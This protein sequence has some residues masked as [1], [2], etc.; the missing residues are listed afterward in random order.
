MNGRCSATLIFIILILKFNKS[1][2]TTPHTYG[3]MLWAKCSLTFVITFIIPI[4]IDIRSHRFEIFTL[5]SEI[6][7]NVDLS[8]RYKKHI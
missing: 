1:G 2:E 5:V 8:L 7:E 4:V 6:H 3:N